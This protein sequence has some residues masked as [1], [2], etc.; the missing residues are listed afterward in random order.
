M[1]DEFCKLA[2]DG[3]PI[4]PKYSD[5]SYMMSKLL[6]RKLTECQA[7]KWPHLKVFSGDPGW[8]KSDMAGWEKP[9]KTAEQGADNFWWMATSQDENLIK[10]SGKFYMLFREETGWDGNYDF[11][12]MTSFDVPEGKAVG[13]P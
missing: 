5:S 4:A 12:M 3:E 1:A 6:I 2:A 13:K 7:T 8:C 10:N 11:S 9:P